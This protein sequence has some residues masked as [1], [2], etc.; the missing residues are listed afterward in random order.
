MISNNEKPNFPVPDDDNLEV[1][2]M[3]DE[4]RQLIDE[5]AEYG[6]AER[7]SR[8]FAVALRTPENGSHLKKLRR[9][10]AGLMMI[11]VTFGQP[12]EAVAP[13]VSN[14]LSVAK[15]LDDLNV[16]NH[17]DKV[18][19]R[20]IE[21]VIQMFIE[22]G[23]VKESDQLDL[24]NRPE[25]LGQDVF[26]RM[27]DT[28]E[29]YY[30]KPEI[31]LGKQFITKQPEKAESYLK[32]IHRAIKSTVFIQTSDGSASGSIINTQQGIR[33]LTN[34]HVVENDHN[35]YIEFA[36]QRL[37]GFAKVVIKND[38][39]DMALL[40]IMNTR[41]MY[42]DKT[43]YHGRKIDKSM[44]EIFDEY[45]I[46]ALDVMSD[47]DFGR[48][49]NTHTIASVGNASSYPFSTVICRG[50]FFNHLDAKTGGENEVDISK[51]K[52]KY[53]LLFLKPD[54]RFTGRITAGD[55]PFISLVGDRK[56][57]LARADAMHSRPGV[58][59]GP[60]IALD[61]D[62]EGKLVGINVNG[63]IVNE[64]DKKTRFFS[65]K[66]NNAGPQY[67]SGIL[68]ARNIN[69]FLKRYGY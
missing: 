50:E 41:K 47:E 45:E 16:R 49:N 25:V 69:D 46:E 34:S 5:A 4:E 52:V 59:G 56:R 38:R 39:R 48:I 28:D 62:G 55:S 63:A 32:N 61:G 10:A 58:S 44:E 14:E 1:R 53:E 3:T 33:I 42:R 20:K 2:E 9:I 12:T 35:V 36:G 67:R 40:E 13:V 27:R 7:L 60:N 6:S 37:C 22:K 17:K 43:G 65:G 54:E 68:T 26:I 8:D 11:G 21:A 31:I 30:F 24:V 51:N 19:R 29:P 66:N 57:S 64:D 18:T 23:G 15:E